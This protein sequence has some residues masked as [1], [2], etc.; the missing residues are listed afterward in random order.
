MASWLRSSYGPEQPPQL[1]TGT[2]WIGLIKGDDGEFRIIV[3]LILGPVQRNFNC[4]SFAC[5]RCL[6]M[7]VDMWLSIL[8]APNDERDENPLLWFTAIS[9]TELWLIGVGLIFPSS[10]LFIVDRIYF[11]CFIFYVFLNDQPVDNRNSQ[12]DPESMKLSNSSPLESLQLRDSS[13][14]RRQQRPP[15]GRPVYI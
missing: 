13:H 4:H 1:V 7:T 6:I 12:S 10:I 14:H 9:I 3:I 11:G 5:Q 8:S 15:E 2:V